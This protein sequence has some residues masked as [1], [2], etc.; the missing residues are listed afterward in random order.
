MILAGVLFFLSVLH[1]ALPWI[2]QNLITSLVRDALDL[3]HFEVD[4]RRLGPTG[5]DFGRISLGPDAGVQVEGCRLDWT[6]SGLVRKQL[7][8]VRILGLNVE[9][10]QTAS[11]WKL[12]GLPTA[13]ASGDEPSSAPILPLIDVMTV[14]GRIKLSG[15]TLR[16]EAPF[17][18]N[19][20]INDSQRIVLEVETAL[21][22]QRFSAGL[23]ASLTDKSFRLTGAVS[24]ASLAALTSLVPGLNLPVS[25]TINAEADISPDN[26][27]AGLTLDS[28]Q[29]FVAGRHLTQENATTIHARWDGRNLTAQADS[30]RFT[31]PWPV[32]IAVRDIFLRPHA[33]NAGLLGCRVDITLA[34]APELGL[35]EPVR[36]SSDIN[37]TRKDEEFELHVAAD[38]QTVRLNPAEDLHAV[39]ES[40]RLNC[41]I[42]T[43][44]ADLRAEG[45]F[46]TGPLHLT[47]KSASADLTGLVLLA[48][49]VVTGGEA[50]GTLRLSGARL[51]AKQ[52]STSFSMNPIAGIVRFQQNGRMLDADLSAKAELKDKDIS[53]RA[54]LRLPLAWPAPAQESGRI[55]GDLTWKGTRLAEISTRLTQNARGLALDGAVSTLPVT[56]HATVKGQFDLLDFTASRLEVKAAQNIVLPGN[57]ARINPV[58]GQISGTARLNAQAGLD[59]S[60]GVPQVPT[61]FT[62]TD[63]AIQHHQTKTVLTGGRASLAFTNALDLRSKPDQQLAF[64][65]LQLGAVDLEKGDIRYQVEGLHSFLVEGCTLRWAGGRVGTHAFRINPSVE[66]YRVE[67]YCDRVLLAQ[68]LEQFG[69]TQVQGGG[70]ANGRIPVRYADGSL[71]FDDGFLYSTPGEKGVLS[72]QGTE[73]LTAGVP[74]D[75]PQYGQLDLAAEALKDFTYEWAKIRMNTQDRELIVSLELDGKPAKPLPFVFDREAGGFARVSASSPGSAFQGIRLDVNFRLPLDQLLQYRHILELINKGG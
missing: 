44:G 63:A 16:L 37:L 27:T 39:L 59:L 64:E 36:I 19:G 69:M 57:L 75:S 40:G 48:D 9:L 21:A 6:L 60:Q 20:T 15:R 67:L 41:T 8:A 72:V 74:K 10:R 1:A 24:D 31:A 11:G 62:L 49:A 53:A 65:R 12:P 58:L 32:E 33:V 61:E 2:A 42:R 52:G 45:E 26:G 29:S 7:A 25:G 35:T 17:A 73:I 18:V 55:S 5:A 71:T 50:A 56:V 28:F 43:Q 22:G 14:D 3:P 13:S 51:E 30:L 34:Q 68:A 23:D 38:L 66:D 46:R 4:I 54:D 70:T 47:Q